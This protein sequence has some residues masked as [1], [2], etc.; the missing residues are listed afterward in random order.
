M[1]TP[2]GRADPFP[3]FERLHRGGGGLIRMPDGYI[4]VYGSAA[5]NSV[6]RSPQ[7]GRQPPAGGGSRI[8]WPHTL[9]DDQVNQLKAADAPELGMWLQLID[10]PDLTRIRRLVTRAFTP[11]RIDGMRSSIAQKF[12]ELMA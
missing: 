8:V 5:C 4:A 12:D 10:P 9:S 7:Y 2:E 3:V 6:M 1:T 11:G